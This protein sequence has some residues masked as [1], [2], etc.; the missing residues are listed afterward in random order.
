MAW[1]FP[2]TADTFVGAPGVVYGVTAFDAALASLVVTSLVA[3]TAK[4]YSVPGVRPVTSQVSAPVVE[5]VK[6]PGDETTS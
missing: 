3:V 4:V 2:R 5:Q 6:P 1:P